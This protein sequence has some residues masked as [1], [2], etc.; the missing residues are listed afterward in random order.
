MVM[1]KTFNTKLR[2]KFLV[3]LGRRK[4]LVKL[5]PGVQTVSCGADSLNNVYVHYK[6]P[7]G[8]ISVSVKRMFTIYM[9]YI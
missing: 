6:S 8:N 5:G 3:K 2:R 1:V 4:F 7:F 9:I